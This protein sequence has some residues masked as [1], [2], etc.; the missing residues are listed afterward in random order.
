MMLIQIHDLPV[1]Y[2]TH[3]GVSFHVKCTEDVPDPVDRLWWKD[4]VLEL[5]LES[6]EVWRMDFDEHRWC[7]IETIWMPDVETKD[8]PS[9]G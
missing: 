5:V 8:L 2:P 9:S 6:G 1:E 7:H 3:P 4:G